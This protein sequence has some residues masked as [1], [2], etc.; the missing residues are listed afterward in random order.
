ME[1]KNSSV[2]LAVSSN[3]ER[4]DN[5]RIRQTDQLASTVAAVFSA[6][7]EINFEHNGKSF[8]NPCTEGSDSSKTA[9]QTLSHQMLSTVVHVGTD[10]LLEKGCVLGR[11]SIQSFDSSE[12]LVSKLL[13]N[14][15]PS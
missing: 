1:R 10:L 13:K 3:P 12:W 6:N 7:P 4:L 11:D 14:V 9:L 5:K 8:R 15:D 2:N